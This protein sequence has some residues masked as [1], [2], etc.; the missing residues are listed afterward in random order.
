MKRIL[1]VDDNIELCNI[2]SELMLLN[3]DMS[4]SGIAHNSCEAIQM[5]NELNPDVVLLDLIMPEGNGINVLEA[6]YNKPSPKFIVVSALGYDDL[7][8]RA[9][10]LGAKTYFNKPFNIQALIDN[11]AQL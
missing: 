9:M 5:I 10:Q 2:M 11:I 1:I 4:I 6:F 8:K 7:S 3:N